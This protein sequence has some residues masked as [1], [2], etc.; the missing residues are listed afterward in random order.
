VFNAIKQI[1]ESKQYDA[2]IDVASN[3][4][5]VYYSKRVDITNEV[6]SK[7]GLMRTNY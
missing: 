2:V 3:P 5:I 1:A 4:N 6:M 7:L